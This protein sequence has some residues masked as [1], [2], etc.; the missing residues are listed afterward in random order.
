MQIYGKTTSNPAHPKSGGF[1]RWWAG[2]LKRPQDQAVRA[3]ERRLKA[4]LVVDPDTGCH[5][6]TGGR[7]S[8]GYGQLRIGVHRL[9][10]ELANGPIPEGMQVLHRCDNPRCCNPDHLMLGTQAEN[11][12]DMRR[13]GRGR[14]GY[15]AEPKAPRRRATTRRRTNLH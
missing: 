10:W 1:F 11:M 13:K 15:T 3:L 14:N 5:V 4:G 9:A 12:A 7:A 8:K 2:W 6:W